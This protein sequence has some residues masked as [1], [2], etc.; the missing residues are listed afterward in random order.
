M[1][2]PIKS[3]SIPTLKNPSEYNPPNMQAVPVVTTPSVTTVQAPALPPPVKSKPQLQTPTMP[4]T[5]ERFEYCHA[6]FGSQEEGDGKCLFNLSMEGSMNLN[7]GQMAKIASPTNILESLSN[8]SN[9]D[10]VS[11]HMELSGLTSCVE[12]MKCMERPNQYG[13][14]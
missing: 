14:R 9:D 6:V 13:G 1:S 5:P 8:S 3:V 11:M 7:M 2:R 4:M 10:S 12:L